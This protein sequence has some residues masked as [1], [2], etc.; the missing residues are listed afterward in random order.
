MLNKQPHRQRL[1]ELGRQVICQFDA[2]PFTHFCEA[3]PRNFRVNG[4]PPI[5]APSNMARIEELPMT[6]SQVCFIPFVSRFF[7]IDVHLF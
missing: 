6:S 7:G 4:P 1:L 2:F 5:E 3:S